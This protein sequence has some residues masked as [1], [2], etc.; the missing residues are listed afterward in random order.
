M[1]FGI[2]QFILIAMAVNF[3]MDQNSQTPLKLVLQKD[4]PYTAR[5]SGTTI[6]LL[7]ATNGSCGIELLPSIKCPPSATL[8]INGRIGTIRKYDTIP[9]LFPKGSIEIL[10]AN[11]DSATVSLH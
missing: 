1:G 3:A 11:N 10:E 7:E 5:D 6:I 8:S 2:M 9:F 4:I